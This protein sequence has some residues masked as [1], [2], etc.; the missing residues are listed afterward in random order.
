MTQPSFSRT[1]G[2]TTGNASSLANARPQRFA[3][4]FFARAHARWCEC[5]NPA[6]LALPADRS[7]SPRCECRAVAEPARRPSHRPMTQGKRGPRSLASL[8][9]CDW[10]ARWQE[11]AE[12]SGSLRSFSRARPRLAH[13]WTRF[14]LPI[15]VPRSPHTGTLSSVGDTR[16][17]TGA[18]RVNWQSL[19]LGRSSPVPAAR[20]VLA[21]AWL[22]EF[23]RQRNEAGSVACGRLWPTQIEGEGRATVRA[24]GVRTSEPL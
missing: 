12:G 14:S 11:P 24:L 19:S 16:R 5:G 15:D 2:S 10:A 6:P 9:F 17:G 23:L 13:A 8:Q 21:T 1:H 4:D 3:T 20:S 18:G 7:P 22:S